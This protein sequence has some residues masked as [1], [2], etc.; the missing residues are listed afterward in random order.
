MLYHAPA[1]TLLFNP[2]IN[3]YKRLVPGFEAP[4]YIC[5]GQKN[6]SALIR[7]PETGDRPN[8]MRAEIRS[9]DGHTNPYLAF[10]AILK[11]GLE[12]I[13]SNRTLPEIF[14]TNLYRISAQALEEK[15]ILTLPHSFEVAITAFEGSALM[16]EM[17]GARAHAQFVQAKRKELHDFNATIT[18]WE[19]EK[20]L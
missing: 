6:R 8:A 17:L 9:P 12:G 2:T 18:D 14:N 16:Q 4:I 13:A 20:Y 5:C 11:A 1:L 3:S 15:G 19:Y 7:L 10:A